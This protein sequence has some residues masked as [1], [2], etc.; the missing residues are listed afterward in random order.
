MGQEAATH[1][2]QVFLE[3]DGRD[4]CA[5]DVGADDTVADLY[6]HAAAELQADDDAELW[7][8]EDDGGLRRLKDRDETV[9][10]V[11]LVDGTTVHV[12]LG[13]RAQA[14]IHL[15]DRHGIVGDHRVHMVELL[16]GS[17][18]EADLERLR[19]LLQAGVMDELR[20]EENPLLSLCEH[21]WC[22]GVQVCLDEGLNPARCFN[23]RCEAPML[24]AASKGYTDVVSCL[25]EHVGPDD[26]RLLV[27]QSS[28]HQ[29]TPLLAAAERGY[30]DCVR[31]LL[32]C[33]ADK[34]A[35]TFGRTAAMTAAYN[36]HAAVMA[37]LLSPDVVTRVDGYSRTVLA[38]CLQ[39]PRGVPRT[40]PPRGVPRTMP[41]HASATLAC[42]EAAIAVAGA[43]GAPPTTELV[44]K[45]DAAK[46]TPLMLAATY[47]SADAMRLLLAAGARVD[48]ADNRGDTVVAAVCEATARG[49]DFDFA[50]QVLDQLL[51]AGADPDTAD[52]EGDSPLALLCRALPRKQ[53]NAEPLV[54]RLVQAG[55]DCA[56]RNHQGET[57]LMQAARAGFV[58]AARM[59]LDSGRADVHASSSLRQTALSIATACDCPSIADMVAEELFDKKP[60]GPES[61]TS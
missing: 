55:V 9:K 11:G 54:A 23:K 45:A 47:G 41:P 6:A 56:K 18:G 2:M 34:N 36:K 13:Q 12:R 35:K 53:S 42:V 43:S 31:V 26:A 20:A 28:P 30:L 16:R 22:A 50:A 1:A 40:M 39:P 37:E 5:V 17:R 3:M 58:R 46:R 33:G 24:L 29:N 4:E 60:E 44:N 57:P 59:L 51:E 61:Q 25:V 49:H 27:S 52:C 21:G 14:R 32:R 15:Q 8:R 38:L 7:V 19:L 10:D 48:C